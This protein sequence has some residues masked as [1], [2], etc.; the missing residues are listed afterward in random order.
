[1]YSVISG[2]ITKSAEDIQGN[3][4]GSG[5]GAGEGEAATAA[6][7]EGAEEEEAEAAAG[8]QDEKTDG[9]QTPAGGTCPG[10][11]WV[12]VCAVHVLVVYFTWV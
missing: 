6:L 9:A 7:D 11:S 5:G 1:M 2:T 3:C 10:T 12:P 8:A 4:Q